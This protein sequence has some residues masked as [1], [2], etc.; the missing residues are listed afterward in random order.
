MFDKVI[1]E[2]VPLFDCLGRVCPSTFIRTNLLGLVSG[3]LLH[4]SLG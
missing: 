1:W 3:V 4:A 2:Y